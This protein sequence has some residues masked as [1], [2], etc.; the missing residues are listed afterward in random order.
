MT[1]YYGDNLRFD[2]WF[3]NPNHAG[4]LLVCLLPF[5][6]WGL[7]KAARIISKAWRWSLLILLWGVNLGTLYFLAGTYSRGAF[8]ALVISAVYWVWRMGKESIPFR[9]G[10]EGQGMNGG[11]GFRL[12]QDLSPQITW[13]ER[14]LS[15]P[16]STDARERV[17]P[18][19]ISLVLFGVFLLINGSGLRVV[20][21]IGGN[22]ESVGN[23][24]IVWKGGLEMLAEN[25]SGVGYG[26]SGDIFMQYY[27]PE[28]MGTGY[29]SLVSTWLT[30]L[31]EHGAALSGGALFFFLFIWIFSGGH[32]SNTLAQTTA[33]A[34][35]IAF[36]VAAFF[37]NMAPLVGLWLIPSVCLLILFYEGITRYREQER[38]K[39]ISKSFYTAL[40][41]TICTLFCLFA[42]GTILTKNR[43]LSIQLID[44]EGTVQI[45]PRE[46]PRADEK[47]IV[48]L[49]PGVW[50]GFY[51]HYLR[52]IV[53]K[54]DIIIEV[55][56][57]KM[58]IQKTRAAK[59]IISGGHIENLGRILEQCEA[60]E[61]IVL[62]P[63]L[64]PADLK[65][66]PSD[67]DRLKVILPGMNP[68][69]CVAWEAVVT[70][71][72]ARMTLDGIDQNMTWAWPEVKRFL[73]EK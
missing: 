17:P 58:P 57:Q 31:V 44:R 35:L 23:R 22:D 52:E 45:S 19:L 32:R 53:Q 7:V 12:T 40:A 8:L 46:T 63:P 67:L 16:L 28:G 38:N 30:L 6:W 73:L 43:P 65:G 61:Y 15:V 5:I 9:Q 71:S 59:V 54:E 69:L 50:G 48:F 18:V 68:S 1:Y 64:S 10:Y 51:G 55:I 60:P 33:K 72:T 62:I 20:E 24:L 47:W 70:N 4:I 26:R 36:I 42:G 41:A 11:T 49:D 25:P 37:T 66:L 56:A 14:L 2:L 3:D 29:K 13:R 39:G 34:A 27:Q 21:G